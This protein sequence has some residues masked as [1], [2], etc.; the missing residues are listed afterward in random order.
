MVAYGN[1]NSE[2]GRISSDNLVKFSSKTIHVRKSY[3]PSS[4][5]GAGDGAGA[6]G[7]GGDGGDGGVGGGGLMT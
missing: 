5:G 4:P 6:G 3:A 2:I 7:V 1:R